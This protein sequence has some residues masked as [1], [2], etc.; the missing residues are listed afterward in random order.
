MSRSPG[1]ALAILQGRRVNPTIRSQ[2]PELW[3]DGPIEPQQLGP[4][5]WRTFQAT[6]FSSRIVFHP[7]TP[8]S[9]CFLQTRH[10]YRPYVLILA[11]Q[12]WGL[13]SHDDGPA[14]PRHPQCV[15]GSVWNYW[16]L[17]GM[18]HGSICLDTV[19]PRP[20]ALLHFVASDWWFGGFRAVD[21]LYHRKEQGV[22]GT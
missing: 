11:K 17:G 20:S 9:P 13:D 21:P 8:P 4:W 16:E 5:L 22:L 19:M 6:H 10:E 7:P 14:L 2:S 15:P 12:A 18:N 3:Q 1:R